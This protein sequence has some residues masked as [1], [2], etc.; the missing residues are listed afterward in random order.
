M[1]NR[2]VGTLE[3][4]LKLSND[5]FT[6][7]FGR[8]KPQNDTEIIF[9]CKLGGRATKASEVAQSLGFENTKVYQG[10]WTEWAAQNNLN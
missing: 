5:A 10:S 1:Q 2:I 3:E 6:A 9:S 4:T 7:R 8:D